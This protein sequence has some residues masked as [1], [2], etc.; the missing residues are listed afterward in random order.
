MAEKT[1]PEIQSPTNL[2]PIVLTLKAMGFDDLLSFDFVHPPSGEALIK[3]LESLFL[4]G[5][6][7]DQGALTSLGK[8]MANLPFDRMFSRDRSDSMSSEA[9]WTF[10]Y[11]EASEASSSRF[12]FHLV[13]TSYKLNWSGCHLV[14]DN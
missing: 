6:L 8:R 11:F 9:T 14:S 1:P 7:D 10:G 13:L 2:G 12:V 4:L 3:T 5:A